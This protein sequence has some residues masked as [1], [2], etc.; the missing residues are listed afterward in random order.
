MTASCSPLTDSLAGHS[1]GIVVIVALPFD[2]HDPP[3]P[4]PWVCCSAPCFKVSAQAEGSVFLE[5][6][7]TTNK[8]LKEPHET[9]PIVLQD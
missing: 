5:R 3:S 8:T 2:F 6:K 1:P 4:A 7:T 9:V